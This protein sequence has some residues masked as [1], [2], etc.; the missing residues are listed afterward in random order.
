VEEEGGHVSSVERSQ[1]PVELSC[2]EDSCHK[3]QEFD[4]KNHEATRSEKC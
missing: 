2:F 3:S 1:Y 4:I